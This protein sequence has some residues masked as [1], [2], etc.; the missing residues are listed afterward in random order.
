MEAVPNYQCD[1][2]IL[3]RGVQ[4]NMAKCAYICCSREGSSAKSEKWGNYFSKLPENR[5]RAEGLGVEKERPIPQRVYVGVR[6]R[7]KIFPASSFC[8][9]QNDK[10]L[11][12]MSWLDT[13]KRKSFRCTCILFFFYHIFGIIIFGVFETTAIL[14]NEILNSL[15]ASLLQ[16]ILNYSVPIRI[17]NKCYCLSITVIF[18]VWFIQACT[19]ADLEGNFRGGGLFKKLLTSKKN[20][21]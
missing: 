8:V 18:N 17:K 3:V 10:K 16:G 20:K 15:S 14:K 1:S 11:W 7:I 9:Y 5:R 21:G 6:R 12:V 4:A 13:R 19:G 2:L